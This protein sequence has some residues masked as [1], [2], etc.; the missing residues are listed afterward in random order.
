MND[1]HNIQIERYQVRVTCPSAAEVASYTFRVSGIPDEM[2]DSGD[3]VLV[4]FDCPRCSER[5]SAELKE[6]KHLIAAE[7]SGMET[8]VPVTE[9]LISLFQAGV[10]VFRASVDEVVRGYAAYNIGK[11]VYSRFQKRRGQK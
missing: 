6:P 10:D 5:I 8:I 1:Q 3:A 2:L 4:K 11:G 9:Y 7:S